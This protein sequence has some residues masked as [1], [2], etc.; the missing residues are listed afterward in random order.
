MAKE[1]ILRDN[2]IIPIPYSDGVNVLSKEELNKMIESTSNLKHKLVIMFLYYAEL[3]LDEA[4]NLNW[5]DIDFDRETIHLKTAKGDKERLVFLHKR[6][7]ETLRIFGTKETGSIFISQRDGKYNKRTIQQIIKSASGKAGIKKN[8][9]PHTLRH[10]FATRLLES[11]ADIR[12]I[13]QL[14]GH[15][16]LKTTQI[17][18]HVANK[19]IKKTRKSTVGFRILFLD[20]IVITYN[21]L[22]AACTPRLMYYESCKR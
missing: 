15:R 19:D 3:R 5:Q 6:L 10:S 7:I 16:D 13:Q 21:K 2:L 18:T 22:T 11:G 4:R 12:Y 17:Y 20:K 9:T 14:I 1:E 8:V